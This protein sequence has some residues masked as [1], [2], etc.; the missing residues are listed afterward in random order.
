[1]GLEGGGGGGVGA[2]YTYFRTLAPLPPPHPHRMVVDSSLDLTVS[3]V[4]D[5]NNSTDQ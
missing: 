4:E 3:C 2:E 5:I 1:M